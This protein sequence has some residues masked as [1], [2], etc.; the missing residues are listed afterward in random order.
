M[1][2]AHQDFVLCQKHI[3]E[4]LCSIFFNHH[5]EL[6]EYM[7]TMVNPLLL[8]HYWYHFT[9]LSAKN[10]EQKDI[11]YRRSEASFSLIYWLKF[12]FK[13]VNCFKSYAMKQKVVVFL[14]HGVN[15]AHIG[16]NMWTIR[17]RDDATLD[18]H[19]AVFGS[20]QKFVVATYTTGRLWAL[21]VQSK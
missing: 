21:F 15:S 5:K 3:A 14:K 16:R 4:M 19:D 6:V 1:R 11:I 10:I 9:L 8:Q 7:C 2:F 20:R 17:R 18:V 12:W 13:F